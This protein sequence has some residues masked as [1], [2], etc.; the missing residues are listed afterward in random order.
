NS[1]VP[2]A[3]VGGACFPHPQAKA[4]PTTRIMERMSPSDGGDPHG[5]AWTG[6]QVGSNSHKPYRKTVAL[7]RPARV[8]FGRVLTPTGAAMRRGAG[9]GGATD[10]H[11]P[12]TSAQVVTS[13]RAW[14]LH[15]RESASER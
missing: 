15:W 6:G 14:G 10:A 4:R 11:A 8:P 1:T 7:R 5:R 2:S 9:A 3:P 13:T 12:S